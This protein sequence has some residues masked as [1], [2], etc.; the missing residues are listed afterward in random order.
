MTFIIQEDTKERLYSMLNE[1]LAKYFIQRIENDVDSYA[2]YFDP[3]LNICIASK[4]AVIEYTFDSELTRITFSFK[5][6][7]EAFV[8]EMDVDEFMWRVFPI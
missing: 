1:D 7:D 8:L 2:I 4:E 6:D 3:Y 5:S